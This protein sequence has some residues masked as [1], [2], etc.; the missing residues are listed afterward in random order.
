MR[1]SILV[2]T[3]VL[4]SSGCSFAAGQSVPGAPPPNGQFR[5]SPNLSAPPFSQ[6]PMAPQLGHQLPPKLAQSSPSAHGGIDPKMCTH[7]PH[8]AIGTLPPAVHVL[9]NI[10]PNLTL[11][12]I[13][14]DTAAIKAAATLP[15]R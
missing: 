1:L 9:P 13:H 14:A 4:I 8:S 5:F 15:A 6:T 10:Y 2:S 7:P 3:F 11:L 12:L